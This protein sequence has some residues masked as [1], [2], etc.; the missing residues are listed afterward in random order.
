[1]VHKLLRINTLQ[2]SDPSPPH[3]GAIS[4]ISQIMKEVLLSA[5]KA[6]LAGLFYNCK[7]ASAIR[8]TLEEMDQHQ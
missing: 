4:I 2:S 6:E 3:N 7:E 1:M 8:T 5:A